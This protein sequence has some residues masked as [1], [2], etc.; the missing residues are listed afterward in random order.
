MRTEVIVQHGQNSIDLAL[1]YYG[2]VE[3]LFQMLSDLG[4]DSL[5]AVINTGDVLRVSKNRM[6]DDKKAAWIDKRSLYVNTGNAEF[7]R[8][9]DDSFD[10]SFA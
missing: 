3:G 9:F 8:Q 7:G 1:Q 4:K 5:D 2:S 6:A 10:N